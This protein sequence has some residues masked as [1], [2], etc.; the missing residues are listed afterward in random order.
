MKKVKSEAQNYEDANQPS[1]AASKTCGI[2]LRSYAEAKIWKT[3]ACNNL[4]GA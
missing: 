4:T 1:L 2:R 3:L